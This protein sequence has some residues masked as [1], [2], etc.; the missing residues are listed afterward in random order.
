MNRDI[1][2]KAGINYEAGLARFMGDEA[3]YHAV[4]E[5]FAGDDVVKRARSAYDKQDKEALFLAVHEAKGASGNAG[6]D[7]V[8]QITAELVSLLRSEGYTEDELSEGYRK[9]ETAY[10]A[11]QAAARE[12]L[13]L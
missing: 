8:Y 3:L 1:L 10:L 6:M 2:Q 4:L 12:A 7:G 11:A 13:V 9:F 5:A